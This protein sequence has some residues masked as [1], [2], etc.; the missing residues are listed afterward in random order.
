M[1]FMRL[2]GSVSG[3]SLGINI[4]TSSVTVIELAKFENTLSLQAFCRLPFP[5]ESPFAQ[6]PDATSTRARVLADALRISAASSS[7]AVSALGRGCVAKHL[8]LPQELSGESLQAAMEIEA[9][10]YFPF[11]IQ[12]AMFD[13]RRSTSIGSPAVPMLLVG[14]RKDTLSL[15]RTM[16]QTAGVQLRAVETEELA[17]ERACRMLPQFANMSQRCHVVVNICTR[18]FCLL[19]LLHGRIV[20]SQRCARRD[21]SSPKISRSA[22]VSE[23]LISEALIE[24]LCRRYIDYVNRR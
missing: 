1:Q 24:R 21:V 7:C 19:L 2:A 23:A 13:Y 12:E 6:A 10:K 9:E 11:P 14:C 8:D 5:A 22:P 17:I 15:V 18:H 16:F 3:S 4:S 20:Y